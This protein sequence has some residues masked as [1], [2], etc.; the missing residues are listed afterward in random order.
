MTFTYS[1]FAPG[2]SMKMKLPGTRPAA[3]SSQE[4]VG[5]CC[6]GEENVT[7]N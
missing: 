7:A 2:R 3:E 4:A 1:L 6:D 5:G